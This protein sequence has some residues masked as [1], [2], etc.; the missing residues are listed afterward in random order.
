MGSGALSVHLQGETKPSYLPSP[1]LPLLP[2]ARMYKSQKFTCVENG[3][4]TDSVGRLGSPGGP[5]VKNLPAN[6]GD[7]GSIPDQA[8]SYLPRSN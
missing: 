2:S 7:M 5:L 6:A 1:F 4:R 3:F 8:R